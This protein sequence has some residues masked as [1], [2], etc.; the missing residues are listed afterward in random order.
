MRRVVLTS[1]ALLALLALLAT[2][3]VVG[4]AAAQNDPPFELPVTGTPTGTAFT[5][6]CPARGVMTGV[7]ARVGLIVDAIGIRC[8]SVAA[9]GTLGAESDVGAL[10]GGGGGVVRTGSCPQGSVVTGKAAKKA[11]P[12]GLAAV[13][14]ECRAWNPGSRTWRGNVTGVIEILASAGAVHI[15][16][17]FGTAFP[18]GS[19]SRCSRTDQPVVRLRGR[20]GIYVDALGATCNEP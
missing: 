13:G 7:R 1:L 6:A 12:L 14:F 20:S 11:V 19:I 9:D 15:V 17:N 2:P 3:P 8:R 18:P 5:R 10:A 4:R 16:A